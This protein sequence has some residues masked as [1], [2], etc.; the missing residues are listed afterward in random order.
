MTARDSEWQWHQ[1]GHMQ[2]CISPHASI[3][4]LNSY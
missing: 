2:I 4:P 1:L 3:P